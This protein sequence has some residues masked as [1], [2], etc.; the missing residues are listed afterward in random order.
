MSVD[1]DPLPFCAPHNHPPRTHSRAP[2]PAHAVRWN[3]AKRQL[4]ARH[5]GAVLG[6]GEARGAR[7]A[8]PRADD[9]EV[10]VVVGHCVCVEVR[11]VVCKSMGN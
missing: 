5:P 8:R 4:H 7:A 9:D 3:E 6:G 2:R 11:G 10:K 1:T